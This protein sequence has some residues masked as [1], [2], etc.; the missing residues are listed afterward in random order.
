MFE[1]ALRT[2]ESAIPEILLTVGG[3]RLVL[4]WT[5]PIDEALAICASSLHEILKQ[6]F[7]DILESQE[8]T[9]EFELSDGCLI[10][11]MSDPAA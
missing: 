11:R 8:V 9:R 10:I 7:S 5:M 2:E 3:L 1:M 6:K 4:P